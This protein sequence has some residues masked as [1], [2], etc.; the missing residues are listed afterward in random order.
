MERILLII[1]F[2]LRFK[3]TSVLLNDDSTPYDTSKGDF[4]SIDSCFNPCFVS[5]TKFV[6][7]LHN[8]K[9][10][11]ARYAVGE[12]TTRIKANLSLCYIKITSVI[13]TIV[14]VIYTG[15]YFF[16]R[17]CPFSLETQALSLYNEPS[18]PI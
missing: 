10:L 17:V 5:K 2:Y 13:N 9:S 6:K 12:T 18:N 14:S 3:G 1:C 16:T 4:L 8:F 15:S 11:L 7:G